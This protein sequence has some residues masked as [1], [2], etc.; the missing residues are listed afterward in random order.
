MWCR[1]EGANTPARIFRPLYDTIVVTAAVVFASP[2]YFASIVSRTKK[3]CDADVLALKD[4]AR[5]SDFVWQT[6]LKRKA[7]GCVAWQQYPY[8]VPDF[9]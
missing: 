3:E 9:V 7:S 5:R 4:E 8:T 2:L 6:K 1:E